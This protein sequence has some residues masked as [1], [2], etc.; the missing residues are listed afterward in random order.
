MRPRPCETT[1]PANDQATQKHDRRL[2]LRS[3][4]AQVIGA[5]NQGEPQSLR[6][7]FVEG[8]TESVPRRVAIEPRRPRDWTLSRLRRRFAV[9]SLRRP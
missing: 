1:I 5:L 4:R 6:L 9:S 8:E 7:S 3:S 2:A